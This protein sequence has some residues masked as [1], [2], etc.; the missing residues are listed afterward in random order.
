M[1]DLRRVGL[2][3]A[4]ISLLAVP[5]ASAL[6]RTGP[7]AND[8]VEVVVTLDE[9]PLAAAAPARTL[10]ARGKRSKLNVRT[11]AS[12][13]YMRTLAA[14]QRSLQSRI[15]TNVPSA[16]FGWQ[17]SVVLNGFSVMLPRAEADRL[18]SVPGVRKVWPSLRYRPLLDRSVKLIKAPALY[19]PPA[20]TTGQGMKIG[21]VDDGIEA[22]HPFFNPAGFTM[23]R[24]FPKG[25]A[26]QTTAKVI[27]ARAFPPPNATWRN[28]GKPF[29]TAFS[30]H[31][32]HVAGI[33]A[34][35]AGTRASG[36]VLAGVAPGAYL[37]NYKVLTVPTVAGVGL[38]GN[39]P[40]IAKG[41]EMAVRDGMDVI[42]LSLGEPEIE[43]SRDLVVQALAGAAAAGVVPV[44]AAGNDYAEFGGG[45]ITSP[46]SAPRAITAAAV[47]P[48]RRPVL[49]SFSSAG[50]TPVSLQLK[51]DVAAPGVDIVSSV[52]VREGSWAAFSGTSMAAPHVAGGAALLKQR[53][54]S[55]TVEQLKS[56]LAQTGAPVEDAGSIQPAREGGGLI[57]LQK[58]DAPLLFTSPTN[59][60]FGLIRRR[61]VITRTVQLQDA[62]GGAAPWLVT[63]E[64]ERAD[65]G[66]SI[67]V[68]PTVT[69]PGTLPITVTTTANA[70]RREL[71]GFV[72]LARGAERRRIPYWLRV[73]APSL[74]RKQAKRLL[75]PGLHAATTRGASASV[76]TYRYPSD[77][78]VEGVT[79]TLAGPE[80]VFRV[81]LR[82]PAVNFGVAVV[83]RAKGVRVEP[84]VV[85]AGDEDRLL[86]QTALPINV[87]PYLRQYRQATPAAGAVRPTAGAYDVVFDGPSLGTAG[88]FRFRFWVN[89]TKPPRLRLLARSVARG[90]PLRVGAT[91]AGS[92]IDP[93]TVIALTDR[94]QVTP[95][96]NRGVL[97][98]PTA[99]LGPGRHRL[100]LQVSDYQE[101][102]NMENAT[103]ILP[104]SAVLRTTF[105]IG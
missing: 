34:G 30:E 71:T 9:P 21:I 91:D 64:Q 18:A 87:N 47:T 60:S 15:A 1:R 103:A 69:A 13:S 73:S 14:A 76:R 7:G 28:A 62:G 67:G 26:S 100:E 45:S 36:R 20:S 95:A 79:G 11:P 101:S 86:G 22:S 54:P 98:I 3:L 53:H 72:V 93:R 8:L 97:R 52:P 56:A 31:G 50:P 84:R 105:V 102:R 83:W 66:V 51:P 41:I 88:A 55:W 16:Q 77:V 104:N 58:A 59:L 17:Y 85:R 81:R 23:P 10:S 4:V 25:I 37:G 96:F 33:A 63:V 12:R 57:D 49:A 82:R 75:R 80:R 70:R 48:E 29:D 27:V 2:L 74:A 40:E 44:V 6:A 90:A 35:N 43:P 32:T 89:D 38:N 39:S 42:N 19:A 46:G 94:S 65:A 78:A 92:G 5:G 99:R 68:P 61:A 24:G